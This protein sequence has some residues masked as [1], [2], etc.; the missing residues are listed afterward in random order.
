MRL[1]E[2]IK[3]DSESGDFG[4]ALDGYAEKVVLLEDAILAMVED[5]GG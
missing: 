2:Q 4:N 1:S 3:R 5:G